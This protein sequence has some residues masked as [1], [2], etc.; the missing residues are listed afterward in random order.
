MHH[1]KEFT[2]RSQALTQEHCGFHFSLPIA[3]DWLHQ[4]TITTVGAVAH[5]TANPAVATTLRQQQQDVE[6]GV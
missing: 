5:G 4:R 1:C 2:L 3:A 6:Q